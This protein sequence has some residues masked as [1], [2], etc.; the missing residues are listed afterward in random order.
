MENKEAYKH[1][2][3]PF[4]GQAC[5]VTFCLWNAVPPAALSNYTDKLQELQ[6]KIAYRKKQQ[7]YDRLLKELENAYS[8]TRRRYISALDRLLAQPADHA[9]DL[10]RADLA[11]IITHEFTFWAP[12][13]LENYA[14]CILPN[15][16][17]WVFRTREKDHQGKP[18]YLPEVIESVKKDTAQQINILLERQ[19]PLWHPDNFDLLLKNDKQ[20]HRA[21]DF[22]LNNPIAANLI[23]DR[24]QW[25]GS[26][27]SGGL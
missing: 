2:L 9:I 14:W 22:T 6:W 13:H 16:V 20:L 8:Q 27:G 12:S 26:W 23:D 10:N 1:K 21:I 18:V 24:R 3:P 25:P 15:H 4:P 7:L 19:G 5:L 11:E 17:H